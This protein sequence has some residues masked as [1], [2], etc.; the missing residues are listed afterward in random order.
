[1]V[2]LGWDCSVHLLLLTAYCAGVFA[3]SCARAGWALQ[4][5][6]QAAGGLCVE[7]LRLLQPLLKPCPWTELLNLCCHLL[8]QV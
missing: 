3:C 4:L 2:W 1:V 5:L 6:L 8:L 7:C